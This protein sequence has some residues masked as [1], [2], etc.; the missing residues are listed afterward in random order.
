MA[1]AIK[2]VEPF[3]RGAANGILMSANDLGIGLGSVLLGILSSKIGM[4]AMYLVCAGI[5]SYP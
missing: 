5:L 3:R 4:S 2:R 1:M